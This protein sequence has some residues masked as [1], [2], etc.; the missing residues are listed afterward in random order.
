[1]S[2]ISVAEILKIHDH[3]IG[4]EEF[5]KLV[6]KKLGIGERMAYIK[7]KKAWAKN[8]IMKVILPNRAVLYGLKEFGPIK[9]DQSQQDQM[10]KVELFKEAMEFI[11]GHEKKKES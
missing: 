3:W 4:A 7:I 2:N 8:E 6:S 10:W 11:L 1:M 5:V 9:L